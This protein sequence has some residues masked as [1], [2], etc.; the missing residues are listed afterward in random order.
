M[1][2]VNV[3]QK[4]LSDPRF[5]ILGSHLSPLTHASQA[6][7][8]V[9]F[10]LFLMIKVWNYCMERGLLKVPA[11]DLDAI[12]PGLSDAMIDA[13]LGELVPRSRA[14]L[15]RIKGGDGRLDW[16]ETARVIGRENGAKGAQYGIKGGRPKT[17]EKPPLGVSEN[18]GG[19][20]LKNPPLSPALSPALTPSQENTEN[21]TREAENAKPKPTPEPPMVHPDEIV[22]GASDRAE[23]WDQF[24]FAYP[25]QTTRD[26]A[27]RLAWDMLPLT[28]KLRDEIMAGLSRWR[29]SGRWNAAKFIPDAKNFIGR[30]QWERDPP[31]D[32]S[33]PSTIPM[34]QATKTRED[35]TRELMETR[36]RFGR[37]KAGEA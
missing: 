30:R 35:Y 34:T 9:A 24:A 26:E 8:E 22:L 37:G 23:A 4:A 14:R 6:D 18:G 20:F 36:A 19:G 27:A 21:G 33:N 11:R 25:N 17:K 7:V 1:A 12:Y 3:D 10:G 5:S 28:A 31:T 29:R 15:V 16:L 13:Q 2:R 32:E